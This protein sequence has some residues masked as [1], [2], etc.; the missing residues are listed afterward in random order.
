MKTIYFSSSIAGAKGIPVYFKKTL[1]EYMKDLGYRVL[2]EHVAL[3]D[4]E[5]KMF[6]TLSKN[7]GV[8]IPQRNGCEAEIRD[9]DARWVDEADFVIAMVDEP[10]LGVGMEI[11]RALLR[12]KRGF[13]LAPILCLIHAD[14]Y[15][16]LSPMVKGVNVPQFYLKIYTD[17]VDAQKQVLLFLEGQL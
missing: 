16:K 1:V 7:A 14:N 10:S 11:E 15:P 12:P 17:E 9:V 8:H 6:E 5:Q 2:S 13:K 4:N 3:V